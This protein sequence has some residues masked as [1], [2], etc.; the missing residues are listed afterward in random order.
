VILALEHG[1]IVHTLEMTKIAMIHWWTTFLQPQGG[2]YVIGMQ[3]RGF[4]HWQIKACLQRLKALRNFV[5][6]R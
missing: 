1:Y 3:D 2:A 5:G 4:A 6:T